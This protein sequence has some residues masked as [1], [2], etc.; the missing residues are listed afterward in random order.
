MMSLH[1]WL[2]RVRVQFQSIARRVGPTSRKP[3]RD[4]EYLTAVQVLETRCLPATIAFDNL[5]GALVF[6]S[7]NG[8]ADDLAV[9]GVGSTVTFQSLNSANTFQLAG[10]ALTNPAF[11]LSS[12]VGTNDTL[13]IDVTQLSNG[14]QSLRFDL[15]DQDD[16]V[17]LTDFAGILSTQSEIVVDLG[18]GADVA[19]LDSLAFAA[20]LFGGPGS[21]QLTGTAFG[22]VFHWDA[23]DGDD[24]ISAG[25][26]DDE[27]QADTTSGVAG[28]ANV[29]FDGGTGANSVSVST[30]AGQNVRY[31][32]DNVG[33]P[34]SGSIVVSDT[35]D[36]AVSFQALTPITFIGA[37]SV[38]TVDASALPA[39]TMLTLADD[40]GDTAG[41]GGNMV[42]GDAG[43]ETTFFS[44]FSGV[45]LIGGSGTETL[46]IDSLD[47]A[48]P[49]VGSPLSV[50]QVDGGADDDIINIADLPNAVT[51]FARNLL[52]DTVNVAAGWTG[53]TDSVQ[54][55]ALL[56]IPFRSFASFSQGGGQLLV[57]GVPEF[58]ISDAAS[59]AEADGNS[60]FTVTARHA[61]NISVSASVMFTTSDGTAIGGTD[62]VSTTISVPFLPTD[63][64]VVTGT[65]AATV[66]V[67]VT[68]E[69][70]VEDNETFSATLSDATDGGVT[71][72]R[73]LGTSTAAAIINNDDTAVLTLAIPSITESDADQAVNATVTLDSAVEGGLTAAFTTALGTAESTDVAFVTVSPLTFI[74]TAGEVRNIALTIFGDQIVEDNETFTVT[75]GTITGAS[76]VQSAAVTS[77]GTPATGTINNDDTAVLTLAI[78]S[79][80]E[81]DADQAVNATV[82]LDSA[83]EGGLTA[84]FTTALGTAESTDVAFVTAGPLTFVGTAG[85]VRNIALTIFGD[86]IVEDNETFTITLGTITGASAVQS[87]AVTSAGTPATGT[88][89]N[90]DTAMLTLSIPSITESNSAQTVNIVFAIDAA[91]EGG[92]QVPISAELG[93]AEASDVVLFGSE[94]LTFVGNAGESFIRPVSVVGDEIVELDETFVIRF[95]D[96]VG[97]TTE[98]DVSITV[99]SSETGV[100]VNDDLVITVESAGDDSAVTS[101]DSS[102][103]EDNGNYTLREAILLSNAA[104]GRQSVNFSALSGRTIVLDGGSLPT[105]TADI[106]ILGPTPNSPGDALSII[107]NGRINSLNERDISVIGTFR[108]MTVDGA[109]VE[110]EYLH[111]TRGG[112][113]G[114]GGGLLALNGADVTVRNSTFSY[115]GTGGS[116]GAI[117]AEGTSIVAVDGSTFMFND[118]AASG[119]AIGLTSAD[120]TITNST[121]FQNEAAN[122]GA[123]SVDSASKATVVHATLADNTATQTGAAIRSQAP[124]GSVVLRRSI[125]GINNSTRTVNQQ[126]VGAAADISGSITASDSVLNTDPLLSPLTDAGG[127]TLV[128][129]PSRLLAG[130]GYRGNKSQSPAVDLIS[131][132]SAPI[133]SP[134][135]VDQRGLSGAGG[136][137]NDAGAVEVTSQQSPPIGVT[138]VR[139]VADTAVVNFQV[140]NLSQP[141][142][143]TTEI[144]VVVREVVFT[145]LN[146]AGQPTFR[147]VSRVPQADVVSSTSAETV[148]SE[149]NGR[150]IIR[151]PLNVSL[152]AGESSSVTLSLGAGVYRVA[153]LGRN[154]DGVSTLSYTPDQ[155]L[156]TPSDSAVIADAFRITSA[157]TLAASSSSAVSAPLLAAEPTSSVAA[158]LLNVELDLHHLADDSEIPVG[159]DQKWIRS[160]NGTLYVLEADGSFSRWDAAQWEQS[161]KTVFGPK[162]ADLSPLYYEN[163]EWL[164]TAVDAV[165]IHSPSTADLL[166]WL[167]SNIGFSSEDL[168][169]YDGAILNNRAVF[170]DGEKWIRSDSGQWYYLLPDGLYKWKVGSGLKGTLIAELPT[171]VYQNPQLLT[172]ATAI[173][174]DFNYDLHLVSGSDFRNL[175]GAQERWV[176]GR[177][178]ITASAAAQTSWFFVKPDGSLNLWSGNTDLSD[179]VFVA[180]VGTEYYRGEIESANDGLSDLY[181][182]DRFFADWKSLLAL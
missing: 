110:L 24:V 118:A 21:D 68:D 102:N 131:A 106:D 36:F 56:G 28:A 32:P 175:G 76:A 152:S 50:V 180:Q 6:T 120:L 67:P 138:G 178:P 18:A 134:V 55:N 78:P 60:T 91:V 77:A 40:P 35:A 105:I 144:D 107:G 66:L 155:F 148:V 139:V 169:R 98:Q 23:G 174:L 127:P 146:A 65:A 15:G 75:L 59:I 104:T 8:E 179:S 89:S 90:D 82:T 48:T 64:D 86:Q 119:G 85:E 117:A 171:S 62:Y 45:T 124:A 168:S 132:S 101:L 47:T 44:G 11:V 123:L 92:F 121:F 83:V 84:A 22:D 115:N 54:A 70:V 52:G 111:L 27:F 137:R 158:G 153:V 69:S 177:L 173:S 122:G 143:Q 135:T 150:K 30:G 5:T 16:S 3:V 181:D 95:G 53:G 26:G 1:S 182:T 114:S 126:P 142:G 38:L 46:S 159:G 41:T 25:D 80:T 176:A 172:N 96:V 140:A 31:A 72:A 20:T 51:I 99:E 170:G 165:P 9:V 154:S 113:A 88:I 145:G 94:T 130:N 156:I 33:V 4:V 74:G 93:S 39:V 108:L 128:M 17:S 112:A 49:I 163:P 14:L 79:I 133:P 147:P 160:A 149:A 125:V 37:G 167:D 157:A 129:V 57:E 71:D 141:A 19:N 7:Q 87:A 63:A 109:T 61:A 97:T 161:G 166:V 100:I 151:V 2:R 13:T 73:L 103:D 12:V 116:G 81:S 58:S 162:V 136:E 43:V 42:S 10:D 29:S 164:L 34:N